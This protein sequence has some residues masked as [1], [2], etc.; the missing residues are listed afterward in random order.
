[1]KILFLTTVLPGARTMGSE[2]ASQALIDAMRAQGADVVTLGYRRYGV[3]GPALRNE[4]AIASRAIETRDAGLMPMWWIAVAIALKLPYS[5]AKYRSKKYIAKVRDLTAQDDIAA[6]VVDH[7]QMAWIADAVPPKV[8]VIAVVHNI[9]HEMY[10]GFADEPSR[11]PWSRWVY[12]RE[13]RLIEAQERRLARRADEVWAFTQ[14]DANFFSSTSA[15]RVRVMALPGG[16]TAP[17]Q[18]VTKGCD[19]ALI[20]TWSWRANRDALEWFFDRVYPKLPDHIG[21]QVAG[22]DAQ[23]VAKHGANIVYR[24]FVPDAQAFLAQ[25]R[26]VAIPTQSGGGIQIKTLD[27]IASGSQVVATPVALRGIDDRPASVTVADGAEAFAHSLIANVRAGRDH[28]SSAQAISWSAQR[29]RSF[30]TAMAAALWASRPLGQ[31]VAATA[32]ALSVSP[33]R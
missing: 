11:R 7:A 30:E 31:D 1:V 17:P 32:S 3:T 21:I 22:K 6:V 4:I 19:I 8:R 16:N 26:V 9:E 33:A 28:S 29:R 24:G 23:W 20:G 15:K 27:A 18:R 13:A 5:A 12:H 25:A 14:H 2:V 10:R